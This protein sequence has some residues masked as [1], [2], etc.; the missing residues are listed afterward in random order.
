MQEKLSYVKSKLK[1]SCL[2]FYKKTYNKKEELNN[3]LM[4]Q[5][6]NEIG[7]EEVKEKSF[8]KQ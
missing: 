3:T 1:E 8:K 6:G 7:Y 2:D 5:L 4:Q